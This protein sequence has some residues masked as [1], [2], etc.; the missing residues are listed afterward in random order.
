MPPK[1]MLTEG[2]MEVV[3]V[4]FKKYE[5]GLREACITAKVNNTELKQLFSFSFDLKL[6][7]KI[8][9]MWE[10]YT[11]TYVGQTEL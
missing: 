1:D 3:T 5:T 2:E 4:V 7:T 6:S 9:N 11:I 8:P 10:G